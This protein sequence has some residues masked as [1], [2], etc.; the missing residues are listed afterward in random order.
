MYI[1]PSVTFSV[2]IKTVNQQYYPKGVCV[3]SVVEAIFSGTSERHKIYV[4][5]FYF[6]HVC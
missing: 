3:Y 6:S 4:L 5:S 2:H 1:D